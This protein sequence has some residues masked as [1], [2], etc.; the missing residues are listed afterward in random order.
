MNTPCT[1]MQC[2]NMPQINPQVA[3]NM[4]GVW[5]GQ[6]EID[7]YFN[8]PPP[9]T[10]HLQRFGKALCQCQNWPGD[11]K[12]YRKQWGRKKIRKS[13]N[14]NCMYF[15]P[16]EFH[17]NTQV[18][19]PLQ[20]PDR[21][22]KTK[23]PLAGKKVIQVVKPLPLLAKYSTHLETFCLSGLQHYHIGQTTNVSFC[24]LTM[25]NAIEAT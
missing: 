6:G 18:E 5:K 13:Q 20:V 24:F 21:R 22:S 11:L 8:R 1:W 23:V 25:Q 14:S 7:I 3:G 2:C 12:I 16:G 15:A 10:R 17:T 19:S 9:D 4:T